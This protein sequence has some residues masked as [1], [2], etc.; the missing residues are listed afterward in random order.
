MQ[1]LVIDAEELV[2]ALEMQDEGARYFLDRETG[3]LHF[4]MDDELDAEW[5]LDEE[6]TGGDDKVDYTAER[7]LEVERVPS[8][9]GWEVMR[10]FVE[11]LPDDR[12]T[13]Q[14]AQALSG[15]SPFRR[16]QDVLLNYPNVRE[17]WFQFHTA[18]YCAIAE[19]WLRANGIEAEFAK[20]TRT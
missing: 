19:E 1:P 6:E 17:Q 12:S 7:F 18:A 9:V 5:A 2:M 8:H 15:K 16:F 3:E 13:Q 11:Q 14:L 10:D 20:R 4:V